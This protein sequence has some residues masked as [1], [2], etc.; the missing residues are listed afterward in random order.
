MHSRRYLADR[1]APQICW[2]PRVS[3]LGLKLLTR[4]AD[5]GTMEQAAAP[6]L[7]LTCP[8]CRDR[9]PSALRMDPEAFEK[10]Q[11]AP[12]VERCKLCGWASRYERRDYYFAPISESA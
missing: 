11:V 10:A 1:D 2:L 3:H 9:F 6:V 7:S 4:P 5:T 8:R 12:T